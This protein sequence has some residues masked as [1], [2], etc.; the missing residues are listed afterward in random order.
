MD[1]GVL[2]C[3]AEVATVVIND[4]CDDLLLCHIV[5]LGGRDRREQG[6]GVWRCGRGIDWARGGIGHAGVMYVC[7]WCV[8]YGAGV[9]TRVRRR[10]LP[11]PCRDLA[12]N[13]I[14]SI[15]AGAF[16]GLTALQSL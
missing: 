12:H 15:D 14:T 13:Q 10:R 5:C 4:V 7:V 9:L 8:A 6:D 16:D 3:G 11:V 1:A 2:F